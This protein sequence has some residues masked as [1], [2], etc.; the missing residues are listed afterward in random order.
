MGKTGCEVVL[1]L[2]MEAA[3]EP[4]SRPTNDRC[5][6]A[7]VGRGVQLMGGEVVAAARCRRQGELGR[8]DGV[9][10]LEE[11]GEDEANEPRAR[12]VERE[13]R[14]PTVEGERQR[15]G[16]SDVQH[17]AREQQ[18]DISPAVGAASVGF[19]LRRVM[20]HTTSEKSIHWIVRKP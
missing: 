5:P 18:R 6:A 11:D 3:H 2:V 14:P 12:E 20:R 1:D 9:R 17:L 10:E 8:V 16:P 7:D 15:D 19:R 13:H 4:C